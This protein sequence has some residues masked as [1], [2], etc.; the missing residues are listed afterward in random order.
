MA[1]KDGSGSVPVDKASDMPGQCTDEETEASAPPPK[2]CKKMEIVECLTLQ[3]VLEQS[4][5]QNFS[6]PENDTDDLMI[7]RVR[8]MM[9]AML[10]FSQHMRLSDGVLA[11]AAVRILFGKSQLAKFSSVGH[12]LCLSFLFVLVDVGLFSFGPGMVKCNGKL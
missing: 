3:A 9:P 11:K 7:Q 4:G 5:F 10:G 2:Q 6:P 12:W 1:T 8:G